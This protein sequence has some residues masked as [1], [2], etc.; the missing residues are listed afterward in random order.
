MSRKPTRRDLLKFLGG[1][2]AG[3]LLTP[4]P[5]KLLDDAAIWTQNWRTNPK[6]PRGEITIRA[7]VCT[8]CPAGCPLR[9][10]CV[11]GRPYR[12]VPTLS[13]RTTARGA[14][15]PL[16]LAAHHLS[17]HPRR[18]R[19][20][21]AP[22]R[23]LPVART[24]VLSTVAEQL[25]EC[26]SASGE[27][28][29]VVLDGRPGRAI[30]ILYRAFLARFPGGAYVPAVPVEE[31]TLATLRGMLEA[32]PEQLGFDL[33]RASLVLGFN[34]GLLE[35]WGGPALTGRLV[36][37]LRAVDAPVA[38]LQAEARP[39]PTALGAAR[40]LAVRPGTES[41]LALGIAH[42]ILSRS[43]TADP[44]VTAAFRRLAAEFPPERAAA[45]TGLRTEEVRDAAAQFVR[46]RSVAV[47]GGDAGGGPLPRATEEVIAALNLLAGAAGPGGG[48]R[49][50][51][52]L[53]LP[54]SLRAEALMPPSRLEELPDGSVSVLIVDAAPWGGSLPW[55]LL[56]R[57][58]AGPDALVLSLSPYLVGH[59]AHAD[60]VVPAPAWLEAIEESPTP[61]GAPQASLAVS[62]PLRSAPR[63]S[64][65]PV[66]FIRSLASAAGIVLP[67]EGDQAR[68][69]EERLAAIL[70]D[71]RGEVVDGKDG[72]RKPVSLLASA[73]ALRSALE[74]GSIWMDQPEEWAE[75]PRFKLPD[76]GPEEFGRAMTPSKGLAAGAEYPL[77][78]VAHGLTGLSG[79]GAVPPVLSK[80]Y[81]ESELRRAGGEVFVN[82]AT[83]RDCHVRE[84]AEA[85]IETAGGR[86]LARVRF[87]RLVL[88]GVLHVSVG[89][90][91]EQLGAPGRR[92][93]DVL[94]LW[95]GAESCRR[96]VAARLQ[97]A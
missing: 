34:A 20:P 77:V 59:A 94:A 40:W 47:G 51:R 82:P 75:P 37:R 45:I 18:L 95:A 86:F 13:G 21:F 58:L 4:A 10:Q 5:W 76:G 19:R 11:A 74:Q 64:T 57:K 81:R 14:L 24:T 49:P 53:P 33:E 60:F 93:S 6:L 31:R 2:A 56:R 89:P 15:C 35:G 55:D 9:A 61:A 39:S 73:G 97:E 66:A 8:L 83:G 90:D 30:S 62:P 1:T 28:R 70:E 22:R 67:G 88:P 65:D 92:G 52:A 43:G 25:R 96:P 29:V 12:L 36:E 48:I 54:V 68:L 69:I 7:A 26:R 38:I 50:R 44:S 16:G 3:T 63:G 71:G 84:G 32:P 85:R 17:W 23:G 80:L 42:A 87:D 78:M 79:E 46:Q 72:S 91:P 41:A 27:K